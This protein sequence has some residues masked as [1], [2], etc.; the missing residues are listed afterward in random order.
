MKI[1]NLLTLV[2]IASV[3]GV[4]GYTLNL[5]VDEAPAYVPRSEFNQG[6]F[7]AEGA[8]EN[9]RRLKANIYTGKIESE[10]IINTQLA[11]EKSKMQTAKNDAVIWESMGPNNVGGRTRAILNLNDGPDVLMAGGVSGGL[12]RSNNAGISW[13]L[14]ESFDPYLVVSSIAQLGNGAIYVATGNSREAISGEEGSGFIGRGLFVSNNNGNSWELVSDFAPSPTFSTSADWATIDVIKADPVVEDRLW[15]GSDHGF[16][17]FTHG[18]DDVEPLSGINSSASVKDFDISA[19]G[20]KIIV[21]LSTQLYVST[22]AGE[23]FTRINNSNGPFSGFPTS[24]FGT[25]EVAISRANSDYMYASLSGV[26]SSFGFL[27]GIYASTDAGSNWNIIAPASNNGGELSQFTPFFNGSTAQGWWDNMLTSAPGPNGE[28]GII[29]GGIR[30]WRWNLIGETPG[31]T[32]WESV[33]ANFSSGPGQA[34]SPLYVHSD[35]HSDAWDSQGRLYIATDGGVYR[36][37]NNGFTWTETV[38]DYVTTHYYSI[39]FNKYGQVLGGLQDNGTL[40]LSLE[41]ANPKFATEFTGGDGMTCEI[42]QQFPDYMFSTSQNGVVYRSTDGGESTSLFQ[43]LVAAGNES[44]DF[45]TDIALHEHRNNTNSQVFVEYTPGLDSP[46]LTFLESDSVTAS[47]DSLIAY[48]PAGTEI[49]VDADNNDYQL[50]HTTTENVNFYSYFQRSVGEEVFELS[51]V[52][53][54]AR[55]QERPQFLLAAGFSQGTFV[56]RQ[57]LKTNGVPE[58]ILVDDTPGSVSCMEWSPDGNSLYI[59]YFNGRLAKITNFNNAWTTEQLEEGSDEYVLERFIIHD[60]PSA[61]TD[62]EVDYSQGRGEDASHKV[63]IAIGGYGGSGKIRVSPNAGI[64]EGQGTFADV[65]NVP[66][67]FTS[68]PAYSVVMDVNDPNILL[69]GT[70]YGIWYSGDNGESWSES[71]NGDMV[72]VPVFDLRQQKLPPWN[73]AN[74]GVVYAGT[75]G[76][77]VLRTNFLEVP[78]STEDIESEQPLVDG[79]RVFPNP[80]TDR[81]SISFDLGQSADVEMFIYSIDGRLIEAFQEQRV[82]AGTNRQVDFDASNYAIGQYI[83]QL[84]VGDLW[85][86]AKFVVTR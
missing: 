32:L 63:V 84:R 36:S 72:R 51:N 24:G 56:T 61:I 82:G 48:I 68:M 31:I 76:R 41:G 35:V 57:P 38:T 75:H 71:N 74:S 20:Q 17:T 64:I 14:V 16:F 50:P 33:N 1:K 86:S 9:Y 69:A 12:F 83:V 81:A 7:G 65:W 62:I 28:E 11:L 34:P 79:L 8:V 42:S 54:T 77:G 45:V 55:I 52:A 37:D 26:G 3:V 19:D 4:V 59:G 15:I 39:S 66:E 46:W 85:T 78:L 6:V 43:D 67:E 60:A 47:G 21:V 13:E 80:V 40:W 30:M 70:E 2:G 18:A 44:S 27:R 53:D 22:D 73:S 58:W 23:S 25:A 29:M 10:D 5:E 49:I